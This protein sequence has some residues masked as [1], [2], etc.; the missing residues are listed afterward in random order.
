M[1]E[2]MN[3]QGPGNDE[4]ETPKWL[5]EALDAEFGFTL[6]AAA[7]HTNALC[8]VCFTKESDGLMQTWGGHNVYVNPP[9]SDI[10]AWVTKALEE[11][12]PCRVIVM[13]LPSRT[14]TEWFQRLLRAGVD[15]R[16]FRKRIRFCLNG[17]PEQSPR[18]DSIIVVI[19]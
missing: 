18:F 11:R 1:N 16:F 5:F 7:S 6:D 10:V 19:R 8:R 15:I 17:V 13:L 4:Y 3:A 9:Y 14:G 12:D 2:G